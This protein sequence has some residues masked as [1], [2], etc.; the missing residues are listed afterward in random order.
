MNKKKYKGKHYDVREVTDL[1]D[2]ILSS[3]KLYPDNVAFLQKQKPS[4]QYQPIKYSK[5]KS[6]MD[7]LGTKFISLGLQGS[8]IAVVGD[9][10]YYWFLTYYATVSGTGAIVPLDKNLT[11]EEMINL[12]HRA[13]VDAVV[14]SAQLKKKIKPLYDDLRSV[15]YMI[16]MDE[17]VHCED[18][19]S[20]SQLIEEGRNLLHD[21]DETFINAE[22]DPEQMAA[23]IFTSGTTGMSKGVMLSHKNIATNVRDVSKL[24]RLKE[25]G[26]VLSVLPVHHTYENTIDWVVFYQGKTVAICEGIKYILK[27]MNE[28]KATALV[29]VP[30]L[31]EKLF[32]GML[33]QAKERGAEEKIRKAIQL[34]RKLKLYNNHSAIRKL[35]NPI[36]K[37]FGGSMELFI[38]GGAAMDPEITESFEAMGITTI[39]GYGMTEYAPIIA[40]NQDRYSIAS[41]VGMAMPNAE[42]KIADMNDEGVG[43]IIVRGPSVMM[44]YYENR[45]ATR[46]VIQD[47]WLH[48]GDL[49]YFDEEG[50]LYIT[51]RKKTVIV[52]KGGKNIFPEEIEAL[53]KASDFIKEALVHGV[54]D[55]NVGNVIVA[56][57][58]QPDYDVVKKE[59]GDIS[60]SQLYHFFR[61]HVEEVNARMPAYKA[62]KR[63]NLRKEDFAMTTTGKIKRYGNFTEGQEDIG[64]VDFREIKMRE[65]K[66]AE[67]FIDSM[68]NSGNHR[69]RYTHGRAITDIKDMFNSSVD[70]YKDNV[71]FRQKFK[72][73][74]PYTEIT[75]KQAQADVNA[76]GTA[77]INRGFKGKRISIIGDTYYQWEAS[78]LA[79]VGGVGVVVPLDKE[80][81]ADELKHIINDAGVEVVLFSK[82]FEKMFKEM[83]STGDTQLELLV[84]LDSNIGESTQEVTSWRDLIEEGKRQVSTGDRQF[85][86]AEIIADELAVI[87]YT[88]GTTGFSKGVMLSN[89]NIAVDL[90]A[91]PTL[92]NVDPEDIFFSVLPVH[93]TYECTCAF[94]MPLYKGASIA[95]CEGLKYIAK[96]LEEVKPTMLLG[97]PVL[98]ETLYKKIW[99]AARA[100]GKD[101]KLEKLLKINRTTRKLGLNITKPFTK[102]IL[103]VFGGRMR[104]LISGG[105][106]IDPKILQFF[107]EI[108]IQAVQ[109]YGLTEC[110]PMTALNPDVE[111]DMKNTSAGHILPGM[112]VKIS[113]PD[114]DGIGEIC[115]K[116]GNVM[117]GYYN[118]PQATEEVL[119]D[120]WFYTGDLGYLDEDEYIFITGRK[121]NIIITDNG[122][123][124]FPEEIEYVLSKIP[125]ISESMVWGAS[126]NSGVNNSTIAATVTIDEEEVNEALGE[127]YTDKDVEVLLWSEIDKVN[128]GLPLF[129]KVKKLIVRKNDF[130]KTTGKKIKRFVESNKGSM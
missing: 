6:D 46:E 110:S 52:T 5:V 71:A 47:G 45:E 120:D 106:A 58:I 42:V 98:L 93:H 127:S 113:N 69:I 26:I 32:K 1:K 10:S 57:E 94:L 59:L 86:D 29:G 56:A 72:K 70:L 38:A 117:L 109:G 17:T 114:K 31:F 81:S 111:S 11:S 84:N 8:K 63:V 27:N 95:F 101:K 16:S 116:G 102:D 78:Y 126:D 50:F 83:K 77:L 25:G 118:N 128:D 66:E 39:Q 49:G 43:E 97:V 7:A 124:V 104:M 115:F 54:S 90:M 68:R 82:R 130:E 20:L 89:K 65:R 36:H 35:F 13:D 9:T 3:C 96:N 30:L 53:L 88:S 91:A 100:D 34:S 92:L 55:K 119:R 123:N 75:Y 23:L 60:D 15:K 44:G 107:N 87:L 62:I 22:I 121:K 33:K 12:I 85:I 122:K 79:A 80:L 40:V 18:T 41:S 4:D 61:G 28:V 76:I 112:Q 105:A 67:A 108:G 74:Q 125:Y 103:K 14:F 2:I 37:A 73:G 129:K 24:V 21:G 64:G 99:K 51:G 48:T 19:L